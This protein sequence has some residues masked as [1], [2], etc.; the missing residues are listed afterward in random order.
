MLEFEK[1]VMLTQK[2]YEFLKN[3]RYAASKNTVQVN[4]YYDTDDFEL[5]RKGITCRIREKNG[6]CM[7]TIK[8]HRLNGSDCSVENAQTVNDRYDNSIFIN[9]GLSYQGSLETLRGTHVLS[10]GVKVMLDRNAYLGAV[11]YE[12]EIEYDRESEK[13]AKEELDWIASELVQSGMLS[14]LEGFSTRIG[15]GKN[16]SERFF[17]RKA[18]IERRLP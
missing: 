2:E 18:G 6:L 15:H 10:A 1:K 9:M 5:N 4:Y 8:E 13:L 12:L 3:H 17:R 16:K 14:S 11:D 7:A